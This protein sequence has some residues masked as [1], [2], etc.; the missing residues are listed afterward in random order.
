MK[1]AE[2]EPV[3]S[4]VTSFSISSSVRSLKFSYDEKTGKNILIFKVVP[5]RE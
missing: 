2:E 1:P 4:N 3:F 5:A